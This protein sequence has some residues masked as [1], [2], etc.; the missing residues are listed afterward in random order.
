MHTIKSAAVGLLLLAVCWLAWIGVPYLAASFEYERLV[1][2]DPET[3]AEIEDL[4][5]LYRSRTIDIKS[6]EW[7]SGIELAPGQYCQQY[8]ILGK[9][10][11]DVIYDEKDRVV[12]M[13]SSFE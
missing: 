1:R 8:L 11:I 7:G 4:L 10:P 9:E 5:F 3:R 2:A 12:H 13:L 6:S